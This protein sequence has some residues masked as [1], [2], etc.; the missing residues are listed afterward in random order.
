MKIHIGR[1]IEEQL[2][3]VGMSKAEFGRRINTSRQNINT[4]LRRESLDTDLL[5]NISKVLGHDFFQYYI[6][7][8]ID[9]PE[10]LPKV[11]L[12]IELPQI[13]QERILEMVVGTDPRELF[14]GIFP[15]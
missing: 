4:L 12:V 3:K 7:Y 1:L 5:H 10:S 8:K 13:A 2:E 14:N 6:I 11:K 15:K 9:D